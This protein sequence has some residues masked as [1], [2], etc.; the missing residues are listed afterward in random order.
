MRPLV[1]ALGIFSG[2]AVASGLF[3]GG[4]GVAT[5]LLA[6]DS[7]H[8]PGPSVDVADLWTSEP[9]KVDTTKQ[10]LERIPSEFAVAD[11]RWTSE[12]EEAEPASAPVD[13][14]T[15]AATR[16]ESEDEHGQQARLAAAH[17]AWCYSRY[18]SYDEVEDSYTSYTGERRPCVSPFTKAAGQMLADEGG[19][20]LAESVSSADDPAGF[21]ADLPVVHY[22]SSAAETDFLTEEHIRECF[23]RY[24]SYRPEDNS[25]QPFGGGPRR[26]CN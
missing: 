2:F 7:K 20:G 15:T 23:S 3:V 24:R 17:V 10:E 16:D 6:V 18:R 14:V 19:L 21:D 4:M 25:Y 22:A 1:A 9:R 12:Q 26:Q 5:Y 11:A 8:E 13:P